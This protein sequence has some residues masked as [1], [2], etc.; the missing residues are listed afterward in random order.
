MLQLEWH[1]TPNCIFCVWGKKSTK[2]FDLTVCIVQMDYL[3][4]IKVMRYSIELVSTIGQE[5]VGLSLKR[6]LA[7]MLEALQLYTVAKCS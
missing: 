4:F 2:S 6:V 3:F 7:G 5:I 1:Y